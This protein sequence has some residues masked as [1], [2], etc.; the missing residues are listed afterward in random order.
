MKTFKIGSLFIISLMIL[1]CSDPVSPIPE[2]DNYIIQT[3]SFDTTKDLSIFTFK[4]GASLSLDN[5][6]SEYG[7]DN[8]TVYTGAGALKLSANKFTQKFYYAGLILQ[9]GFS[10]YEISCYVKGDS[11][12]QEGTQFDN[13]YIGFQIKNKDG[14]K[15]FKVNQY[16]GTFDWTSNYKSAE[17]T[18][19]TNI[20]SI[21]VG[22]FLAI[23]GSFWVDDIKILAQ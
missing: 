8:T 17:I 10:K 14:T 18:D 20:E 15:T 13:C 7:I 23:S 6:W 1:A 5:I 4:L 11:L 16:H 19:W 9:K 3:I 22:I 21:E 2:K 12:V